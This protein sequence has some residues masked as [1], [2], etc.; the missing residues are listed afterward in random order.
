MSLQSILNRWVQLMENGADTFSLQSSEVVTLPMDTTLVF[1][2]NL[3]LNELMDEAY[4]RRITY[5]IPVSEPTREEFLEIARRACATLGLPPD[6][7]ALHYLVDRL[8]AL[9]GVTPKSCYARDLLQTAIDTARYRNEPAR[10]TSEIVD[11]SLRMYLGERA[12][13]RRASGTPSGG[14]CSDAEIDE[15]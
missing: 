13:Q 7:D 6:A 10:L 1:S 4:L 8:Y 14:S 2:T 11:W 12:E 3:A 9:P 5:K 15:H